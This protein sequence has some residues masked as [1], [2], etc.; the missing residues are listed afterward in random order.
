MFT[1]AE[2]LI[3]II[4]P[5]F[6]AE[7]Y[8]ND[9]IN[10]VINQSYK[11]WELL[12]VNDGSSDSSA[13]IVHSFRDSR[14]KYIKQQNRGVAAARNS[15]LSIMQGDYFCFL[16]ADD[17]MPP[18]S[19]ESRL[20]VFEDQPELSFV[21]GR[22]R[23]FSAEM[24]TEVALWSPSFSGNPLADLLSLSGKSFFG[25]TWMI[26][27]KPGKEYRFKEGLTH[28][29][30]LLFFI[31]LARD[32]GLYGYTNESVLHY[33]T[34][35]QSA[36]KNLNGLEQGYKAVYQEIKKMNDIPEE[37]K[38]T[39]ACKAKSIMVRSYLGKRKL[40]DSVRVLIDDWD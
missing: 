8:F 34:G 40:F 3:S 9:S 27:R 13:D 36:M 25:P 10:S 14:I 39:F 31:E 35:H 30:D 24:S 23:K 38:R 21:D 22:V 11:N 33:R 17:T 37:T 26:K 6:N 15:G 5:F 2:N 32:G 28:G 7:Q 18:N 20:K 1:K 12:A 19:L 29:E 4:I 16:D